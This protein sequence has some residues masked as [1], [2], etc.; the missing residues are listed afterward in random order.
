MHFPLQKKVEIA[1]WRREEYKKFI[2][3][4]EKDSEPG[5][6]L[7]LH[8]TVVKWAGSYY[9]FFLSFLGML[10]TNMDQQKESKISKK[11]VSRKVWFQELWH[12]ESFGKSWPRYVTRINKKKPTLD[13]RA[14]QF[15]RRTAVTELWTIYRRSHIDGKKGLD[16]QP[17]CV[18]PWAIWGQI[19]CQN[20]RTMGSLAHL[21]VRV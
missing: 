10:I 17:K 11:S 4:F 14:S 5:G 21:Y 20:V 3:Y 15:E 19:S 16:Q 6:H 8:S 18:K 9:A 1:R 13:V 12:I 2:C 7:Y